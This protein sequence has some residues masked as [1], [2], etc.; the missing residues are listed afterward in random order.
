MLKYLLQKFSEKKM[1][2]KE[3]KPIFENVS[4]EQNTG[5]DKFYEISEVNN[6]RCVS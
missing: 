2:K 1:K 4:M 5:K 3:N 6:P